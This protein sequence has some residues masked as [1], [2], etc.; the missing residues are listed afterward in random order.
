MELF[1]FEI[2]MLYT[3]PNVCCVFIV[4]YSGVF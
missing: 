1:G 4:S 2:S 3:T